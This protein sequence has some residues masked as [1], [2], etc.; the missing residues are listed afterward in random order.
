MA[1]KIGLIGGLAVRA[2]I[3]YYE[4]LVQRFAARNSVPELLLTHADVGRVL[5]A[6]QAGDRAALGAYLAGLANDLF[7]GGASCVAITAIAPHMSIAEVVAGARGHIVNALDTV[8]GGLQQAGFTRVA[9]FGNKV[10]MDT[11]IFGAARHVQVVKHPPAIAEEMHAIYTDI[12]LHGKRGTRPEMERLNEIAL[13]SIAH[14][15]A[16]AIV[17]AGTDL[18]SFY[19]DSEPEYPYLDVAQLHIDAIVR[20]AM[21]PMNQSE[22]TSSIDAGLTSS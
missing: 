11:D 15:G 1:H 2:G 10:V 12:A 22:R 18:S 9:V 20:Y 14:R 4:Q 8:A 13:E 7:A 19:A 5:R 6:V 3:F 16:D 17:L 21:T